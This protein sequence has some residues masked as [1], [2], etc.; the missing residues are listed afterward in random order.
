[1]EGDSHLFAASQGAVKFESIKAV[2]LMQLLCLSSTLL[3]L[4]FAAAFVK[5]V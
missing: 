1:M 2:L 4:L 3:C 5:Q